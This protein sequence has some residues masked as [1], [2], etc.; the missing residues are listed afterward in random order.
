MQRMMNAE[1]EIR[2]RPYRVEDSE[3][4]YAAVRESVPE[5]MPWMPW[6]HPGYAI[7]ESRTWLE[8]Q[9]SAFEQQKAF[10]FAILSAAGDYL[11]GC[12]LNQ[13]DDVNRRANLGYWVRTGA[14]GRG[15]ATAAVTLIR[16]WGF[17]SS[18]LI[19]LE[20]VIAVENRAS[21]RVAEKSGAHFEGILRSRLLLQGTPH[22]AAVHSFIRES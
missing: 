2:I 7:A 16:D 6:C 21:R 15:V 14:V 13:I 8:V 1:P 11:G 12:G 3:A 17:E 5:L 20:I 18:N 19:R 10:E 4:V 22:D 9:V